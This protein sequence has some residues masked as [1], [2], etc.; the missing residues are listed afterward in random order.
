MR[1][2]LV[3]AFWAVAST[4]LAQAGYAPVPYGAPPTAG[5]TSAPPAVYGEHPYTAAQPSLPMVTSAPSWATQ[6]R[7]TMAATPY[8]W[9]LTNPYDGLFLPIDWSALMSRNLARTLVFTGEAPTSASGVVAPEGMIASVPVRH[10]ITGV[11][12]RAVATRGWGPRNELPAG[13]PV[14]AVTMAP[15]KGGDEQT[16]WCAPLQEATKRGPQ[17]VSVCLMPAGADRARAS[18][19]TYDALLPYQITQANWQGADTFEVRPASVDVVGT[20]V[21][22]AYRFGGWTKSEAKVTALATWEGDSSFVATTRVPVGPDGAAR[23]YALGA[24][25]VLRRTPAD[26]KAATVEVVGQAAVPPAWP[27]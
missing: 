26:A 22:L 1:T 8:A 21:R 10:A 5:P 14:F 11:L 17:W 4:C 25:Y 19:R 27:F 6:A 20:P 2:P 16:L 18:R 9:A 3:I 15:R 12:S 24:E 13:S 23:L 7:S